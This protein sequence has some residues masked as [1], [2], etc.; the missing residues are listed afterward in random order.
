[1]IILYIIWVFKKKNCYHSKNFTFRNAFQWEK[2]NYVLLHARKR[3]R[4]SI[5]E[6][7]I[8]ITRCFWRFNHIFSRYYDI[9]THHVLT[10]YYLSRYNV[11][12]YIVITWNISRYKNIS[13]SW[14]EVGTWP[15]AMN[16]HHHGNTGITMAQNTKSRCAE[17]L[18]WYTAIS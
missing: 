1:M 6:K 5:T 14:A 3:K 7:C 10:I 8:V 17:A 9:Q 4:I 12:T 13:W 18:F 15:F 2:Q 11:I 16:W